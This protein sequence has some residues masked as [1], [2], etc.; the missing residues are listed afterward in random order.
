LSLTLRFVRRSGP[1]VSSFHREELMKTLL[2]MA[3][4]TA[5]LVA[6]GVAL[7]QNGNMMN[8]GTWG[9]GW[10]GGY[11]GIWVPILLVIVVAGLVAWIFKRGGK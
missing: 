6:T 7:A 9:V 5:P 1:L 2:A 4:G 8:G 3:V 10:M 11:G